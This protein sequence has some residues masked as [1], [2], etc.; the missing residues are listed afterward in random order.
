MRNEWRENLVDL[1]EY[2]LN[3]GN[4]VWG[5]RALH[6]IKKSGVWLGTGKQCRVQ[7]EVPGMEVGEI[8]I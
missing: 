4:D 8:K 3:V 6:S 1:E 7:S 2:S 5:F